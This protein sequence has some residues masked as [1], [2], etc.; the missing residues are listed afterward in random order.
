MTEEKYIDVTPQWLSEKYDECNRKYFDGELGRCYF[1]VYKSNKTG[2]HISYNDGKGFYYERSTGRIFVKGPQGPVYVNKDNFFNLLKPKIELNV[3]RKLTEWEAVGTLLHEMVHYWDIMTGIRLCEPHGNRFKNKL[4]QIAQKTGAYTFEQLYKS[5]GLKLD[6]LQDTD[7]DK[8]LQKLQRTTPIICYYWD[9]DVTFMHATSPAILDLL[10]SE[11][12]ERG[13][14]KIKTGDFELTKYMFDH[15]CPSVSKSG[16]SAYKVN[17]YMREVDEKFATNTVYQ[18]KQGLAESK[19][20]V[21][22]GEHEIRRIIREAYQ[23]LLGED[24]NAKFIESLRKITKACKENGFI[25]VPDRSYSDYHDFCVFVK[26]GHFPNCMDEALAKLGFIRRP[27]KAGAVEARGGGWG[28]WYT[29]LPAE[30]FPEYE[31]PDY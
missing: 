15:G 29:D 11:A 2:G 18:Y 12:Y 19:K 24:E 31:Y 20:S 9:G 7:R 26:R 27:D 5:E 4:Y 3:I 14:L 28:V 30:D 21:R 1:G 8:M 6:A 22:L 23:E 17:K 16:N 13:I 10:I 25:A